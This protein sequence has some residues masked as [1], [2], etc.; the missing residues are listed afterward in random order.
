R[1]RTVEFVSL[2]KS[3][4]MPGVRVGFCCGNRDLVAALARVKSYLD[5][6]MLEPIQAAAIVALDRCGDFPRALRELYRGRARALVQG[7]GEAGWPV[8]MPGGTMFV[9]APIPEAQRARGS[10]DFARALFDGA[11]VAVSAGA[12]FGAVGSADRRTEPGGRR[13]ADD[14]VRFALVEDEARTAEACRAIGRFLGGGA[15]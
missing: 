10:W 6:G 9:W 14:Y 7:L 13:S 1:E 15:G 11:G 4:N 3:Y 12:G 8:A 2:S 5:Y